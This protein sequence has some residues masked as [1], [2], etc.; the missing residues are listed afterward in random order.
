MP[1]FSSGTVYRAMLFHRLPCEAEALQGAIITVIALLWPQR[2]W[3]PD[4]LELLLEPPLPLPERWD[5]LKR[6][7]TRLFHQRLGVLRIHA[8]RLSGDL[9]EHSASLAEWLA[10][11]ALPDGL[12]R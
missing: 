2:E 4:L 7:H 12:C 5:L 8:W 6:P 1:C 10:D 9:D 11:L 3:F